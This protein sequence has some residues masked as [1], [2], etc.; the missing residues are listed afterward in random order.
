MR[1][2]VTQGG[3]DGAIQR[4]AEDQ[5]KLCTVLPERAPELLR[6]RLA[7]AAHH[8]PIILDHDL[9]VVR[10]QAEV[11]QH[12][13]ELRATEIVLEEIR[14]DFG[15]EDGARPELR[16]S[17]GGC[18]LKVQELREGMEPLGLPIELGE[19]DEELVEQVRG[20]NRANG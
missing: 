12:W 2:D 19:P 13:K 9:G 7:L 14:E 11:S 3:G 6:E 16:Q 8:E 5:E 1:P 20:L 4:D 15:G 17:L 18:K 10:S